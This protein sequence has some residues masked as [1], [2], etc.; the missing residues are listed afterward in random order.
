M[1]ELDKEKDITLYNV[2]PS[3]YY[4]VEYPKS[5]IYLH[6]TAGNSNGFNVFKDWETNPERIATCMTICGKSKTNEFKDGQ[7]V[8]GYG[9]KLW[10]YHLGLKESTFTNFKLP[11]KSLDKIYKISREFN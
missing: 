5:E 1:N 8:Q 7:I 2:S 3:Q 10:A 9:S 11:Y 6:H 4:T